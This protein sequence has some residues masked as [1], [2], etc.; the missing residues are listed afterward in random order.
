VDVRRAG[1]GCART[2]VRII[3]SARGASTATGGCTWSS[4]MKRTSSSHGWASTSRMRMSMRR[5]RKASRV[6][7]ASGVLAMS[8]P[9]AATIW[10]IHQQIQTWWISSIRSAPGAGSVDREEHR[11]EPENC[12]TARGTNAITHPLAVNLGDARVF[13]LEVLSPGEEV[14]LGAGGSGHGS[15][16]PTWSI[17][18]RGWDGNVEG[19]GSGVVLDGRQQHHPPETKVG[20]AGQRAGMLEPEDQGR[21][22]GVRRDRWGAAGGDL[23][24]L[25]AVPQLCLS[26]RRRSCF[27]RV[28]AR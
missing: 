25:P 28:L 8:S 10:K 5:A 16:C 18:P 22:P 11:S 15:I 2:P 26:G 3:G 17:L 23:N 13:P 20:V 24:P 21:E 27:C 14:A 9:N 19:W 4:G 1:S 7:A 6:S 12:P